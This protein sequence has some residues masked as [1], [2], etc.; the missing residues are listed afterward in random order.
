MHIKFYLHKTINLQWIFFASM[1]RYYFTNQ[2]FLLLVQILPILHLRMLTQ[3]YHLIFAHHS[4]SLHIRRYPG[5]FF[6]VFYPVTMSVIRA[7]RSVA[8]WP[9]LFASFG[10]HA[11]V[12]PSPQ[13]IPV[14]SILNTSFGFKLLFKMNS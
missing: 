10:I 4:T 9:A 12:G 8:G 13:L 6:P 11:C 14:S 3:Y 2:N 1:I 5:F 7:L